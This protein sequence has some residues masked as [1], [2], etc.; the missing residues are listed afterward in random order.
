MEMACF[1]Q[2]SAHGW[3]RQPLHISLT[4]YLLS[5]QEAQAKKPD[6]IQQKEQKNKT[7]DLFEVKDGVLIRYKGSYQTERK[8]IL[9]ES[10]ENQPSVCI[11]M[12][13]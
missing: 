8:I 1:G 13:C 2:T 6:S 7:S 10:T 11:K 4:S 3:A 5:S 9:P 12:S